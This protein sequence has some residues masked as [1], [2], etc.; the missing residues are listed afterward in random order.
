VLVVRGHE[1]DGSA[2]RVTERFEH[3]ESAEAGHIDVEKN[4]VRIFGS[5]ARHRLFPVRALADAS[6]LRVFREQNL[7]R[8]ARERLVIDD[9]D[10]KRVAHR[11][12]SVGEV[13]KGIRIEARAPPLAARSSSSFC[14]R[15]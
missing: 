8:R 10:L 15:P 14:L 1:D 3:F 4:D 5:N 2:A 9:H 12:I 6:D 11:E 7:E 13:W